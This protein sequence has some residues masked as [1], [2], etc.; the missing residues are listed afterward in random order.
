MVD[1]SM[2][3]M[4]KS[5]IEHNAKMVK[6]ANVDMQHGYTLKQHGTMNEKWLQFK[7]SSMHKQGSGHAKV[8]KP[9]NNNKINSSS[10]NK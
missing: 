4:V 7:C 9:Q 1:S 2:V 5:M 6:Q 10:Y 8:V 3:Q